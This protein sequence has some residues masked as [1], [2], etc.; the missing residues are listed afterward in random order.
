MQ[1]AYNQAINAW[2]ENEVPIG[3]VISIGDEI[4]ASCDIIKQEKQRSNGSACR[5][6]YHHRRSH[7]IGD[8]RLNQI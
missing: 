4:I 8:W 5:N 7:A 3:A 6:V 2:N 1:H